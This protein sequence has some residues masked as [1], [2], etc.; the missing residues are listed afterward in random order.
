MLAIR[1]RSED[2]GRRLHEALL[3]DGLLV[4]LVRY[5]GGPDGSWLRLAVG[6]AHGAEA[7]ERLGAALARHLG[8]AL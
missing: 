5:P 2:E 7:I 6:A 8:G 3:A 4:P 1:P